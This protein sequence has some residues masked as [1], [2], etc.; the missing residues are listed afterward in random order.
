VHIEPD[1]RIR[2]PLRLWSLREDVLVEVDEELGQL[3][4]ATEWGEIRLPDPGPTVRES[5]WRMQLGPTSLANVL[6]DDGANADK[7]NWQRF[8]EVLGALRHCVVHSLD[9]QT[10]D[11]PLLSAV[12]IARNADFVLPN[13]T[14]EDVVRISRF[15]AMRAGNGELVLES[16]LARHRMVVHYSL[17]A[18]VAGA[19]NRPMTVRD[20][21][22]AVQVPRP[23]VTLIVAYLVA[24][25]MAV[26]GENGV[27]AD[28][29]LFAE[30][31]DPDLIPWSHADLMFHTH[32]RS[33]RYQ[34]PIGADHPGAGVLPPAPVVKTIPPGRRFVLVR[35]DLTTPSIADPKLS[36]VIENRRSFHRFADEP[37]TVD[38][39]GELL[40]RTARIRSSKRLVA[41]D[42]EYVVSDRPYP[43]VGGLHE[44]E[45]YLT[46]DRC[47]GLPHGIYHYDPVG[48][49]LTLINTAEAECDEMLDAARIAAGSV[50]RP[51]A[52][53]T[54]TARIA[55]LSWLYSGIAYSTALKH[56]GVL[57]QTLYLVATAMN[58]APCALAVGDTEIATS[59]LRLRWPVEVS[60]GEFVIGLR[61]IDTVN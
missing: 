45:L 43:S 8:E 34:G 10:G 11:G 53:I 59:A 4:I 56:V 38:Q 48:H 27:P 61:P 5:L 25:G 58:L 13:L 33:G 7:A 35:P 60:V 26:L 22:E 39:L 2:S 20:L 12:P 29:A 55:R 3:L 40:Y 24:A 54:M 21:A 44:L 16:P 49:A 51:P 23:L 30:D 28:E 47:A 57:Q 42:D 14:G 9:R 32:S 17:A 37:P 1:E 36:E 46:I 41:G 19:I 15:T 18:W 50:A 6:G 52:L 31:S